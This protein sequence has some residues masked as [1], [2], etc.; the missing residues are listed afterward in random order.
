MDSQDDQQVPECGPKILA[1][2][3][4]RSR[5]PATREVLVEKLHDDVLVKVLRV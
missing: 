5:T 4:D 1:R 2:V 3:N